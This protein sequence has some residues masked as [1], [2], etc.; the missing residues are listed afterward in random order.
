MCFT[1]GRKRLDRKVVTYSLAQSTVKRIDELRDEKQE[2][3]MMRPTRVTISE[4]IDEA[5]AYFFTMRIQQIWFKCPH[6]SE[7]HGLI[8]KPKQLLPWMKGYI[9]CTKC[10]QPFDPLT[11]ERIDE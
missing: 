11:A 10:S 1:M 5:I 4:I 8:L 2:R 7:E 3:L 6:C 9:N